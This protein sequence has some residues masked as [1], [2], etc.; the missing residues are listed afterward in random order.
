MAYGYPDMEKDS[1]FREVL[2]NTLK[3]I[4]ETLKKLIN[5]IEHK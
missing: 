1:D 5:T 2:I 3:D 4:N